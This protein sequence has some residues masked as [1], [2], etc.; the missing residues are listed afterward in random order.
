MQPSVAAHRHTRLRHHRTQERPS[1]GRRG[2]PPSVYSPLLSV[3][4]DPTLAEE[5][6]APSRNHQSYQTYC[7]SGKGLGLIRRVTQQMARNGASPL[8]TLSSSQNQKR[9][10]CGLPSSVQ[11]H[12][13]AVRS[14]RAVSVSVQVWPLPKSSSRA[15]GGAQA[16]SALRR[17]SDL[18]E[19]RMPKAPPSKKQKKEVREVNSSIPQQYSRAATGPA[20]PLRRPS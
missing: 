14:R 4:A 18:Y 11:Q 10:N 20:V 17:A 19:T 5:P 15:G 3:G 13:A 16:H 1:G 9:R 7:D 2:A 6:E 12:S 8:L